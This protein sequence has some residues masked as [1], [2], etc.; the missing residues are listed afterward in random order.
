MNGKELSKQSDVE[1]LMQNEFL[2]FKPS[3]HLPTDLGG[4]YS[5]PKSILSIAPGQKQQSDQPSTHGF[6]K[7][8]VL[9]ELTRTKRASQ[10]TSA[11]LR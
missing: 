3:G 11:L 1:L 2:S 4:Q 8:S 6:L 5:S 10:V 9:R 7:P